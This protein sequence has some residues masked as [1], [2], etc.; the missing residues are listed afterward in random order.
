MLVEAQ[1]TI[2]G[3]KAVWDAIADI[4]DAAQHLSGVEKIEFVERPPA[5]LVGMRWRETRMYFG[6]PATVEKRITE[7]VENKF[8]KTAAESDGFS[9]PVDHQHFR[10]R[11]RRHA[12]Q[13]S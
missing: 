10:E 12:D 8:Y 3:S 5:G 9:V 1:V 13:C 11:L 6:K 2:N 7:L 4:E